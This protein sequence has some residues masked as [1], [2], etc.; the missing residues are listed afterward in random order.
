MPAALLLWHRR[1]EVVLPQPRAF[2]LGA[3][4]WIANLITVFFAPLVTI[5]YCFPAALPVTGGTVSPRLPAM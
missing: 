5:M 4:G 1:A 2:K 3:F